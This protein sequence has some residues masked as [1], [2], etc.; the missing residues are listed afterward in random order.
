MNHRDPLNSSPTL[1]SYQA[2]SFQNTHFVNQSKAIQ[3]FNLY[4]SI[5]KFH[6]CIFEIKVD[7]ISM[8]CRNHNFLPIRNI[9][10]VA[11]QMGIIFRAW[12]HSNQHMDAMV[13]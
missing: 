8:S 12:N 10:R 5:T 3:Y 4:L 13:K 9:S 1:A 11:V 2:P 7:D 6:V